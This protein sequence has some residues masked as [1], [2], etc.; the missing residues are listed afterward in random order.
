LER[1]RGSDRGAGAGHYAGAKVLRYIMWWCQ[2][3]AEQVLRRCRGADIS[4]EVQ[5]QQVQ[6][7]VQVVEQV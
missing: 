1:C 3:S 2:D 7:Q 6:V 5:V 4:M